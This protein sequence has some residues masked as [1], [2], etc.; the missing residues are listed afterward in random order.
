MFW[1]GFNVPVK[2]PEPPNRFW[3]CLGTAGKMF[4]ICVGYGNLF[5]ICVGYVLDMFWICFEYVLDEFLINQWKRVLDMCCVCLP[6]SPSYAIIG[7]L[8]LVCV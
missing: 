1:I 2:L 6:H 7:V 4:W 8:L 5:W 3:K